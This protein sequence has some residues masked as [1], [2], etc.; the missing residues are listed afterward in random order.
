MLALGFKILYNILKALKV[1]V[2]V[3]YLIVCGFVGLFFKAFRGGNVVWFWVG[4]A[5]CCTLSVAAWTVFFTRHRRVKE[6]KRAEKEEQKEQTDEQPSPDNPA[7]IPDQS[8]APPP[9][10]RYFAVEGH[11][12]FFFAEYADRY[13]LYE[14]RSDGDV[15]IR[16]DYKRK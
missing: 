9:S 8:K 13:E 11:E 10:V 12:N 15:Y 6:R 16:T 4:F 5:L 1:R 2:L 14:R 7:D 3:L